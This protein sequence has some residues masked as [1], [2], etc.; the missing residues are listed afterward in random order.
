M[1]GKNRDGLSIIASILEAANPKSSK[2][3]IMLNANLSYNLLE[4]YL[5]IVEKTGFIRFE[6]SKYKLTEPGQEFLKQYKHFEN[7]YLRAQ[8]IFDT[9]LCE[10]EKLTQLCGVAKVFQ[11]DEELRFS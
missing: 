3:R 9:L 8:K 1:L 10:R 6:D 11:K 5:D 2:T 7:R 4:K